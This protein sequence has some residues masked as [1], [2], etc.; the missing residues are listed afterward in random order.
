MMYVTCR[1]FL[2]PLEKKCSTLK[3]PLFL[4]MTPCDLIEVHRHFRGKY[5]L[6]FQDLKSILA[7]TQTLISAC[8]VPLLL[9]SKDGGSPFLRNVHKFL[10]FHL[11]DWL[12]VL[13][14]EPENG[15]GRFVRNIGKLPDYTPLFSHDSIMPRLVPHL[16]CFGFVTM[17]D[18]SSDLAWLWQLWAREYILMLWFNNFIQIHISRYAHR[19]TQRWNYSSI[20]IE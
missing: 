7:G 10:C 2:R 15:G 14:F 6:R 9:D 13:F 17:S 1:Y 16:H 18:I 4:C 20:L 8:M 3:S 12:L 11:A 5:C 19:S